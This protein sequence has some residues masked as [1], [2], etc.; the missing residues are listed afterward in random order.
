MGTRQPRTP[1]IAT[2]RK[3]RRR[4]GYTT[5]TGTSERKKAYLAYIRS[6]AWKAF[7]V[8]WWAEYDRRNTTRTCYCCAK[9]QTV[10]PSPLELHHRTY[11]HMGAEHYDDLVAVCRTCHTWI[12]RR[13]RSRTTTMTIWEITEA[14]RTAI[15]AYL[16]KKEGRAGGR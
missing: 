12:T 14:R 8:A 16:A 9:P 2:F 11:E 15:R 7:R 6:P 5:K 10:L 3:P 1:F 4:R 13:Q